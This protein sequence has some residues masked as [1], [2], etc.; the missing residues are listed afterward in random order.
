MGAASAAFGGSYQLFLELS[1]NHKLSRQVGSSEAGT[2]WLKTLGPDAV[3][4]GVMRMAF[5]VIGESRISGVRHFAAG[6]EQRCVERLL[7]QTAV[8]ALDE[9]VL[10]GLARLDDQELDAVRFGPSDQGVGGQP[11]AGVQVDGI[12]AAVDPT[13]FSSAPPVRATM[14]SMGRTQYTAL[15]DC[16][17]WSRSGR[18]TPAWSSA[19]RP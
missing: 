19:C 15:C 5:A 11:R 7:T 6:I 1:S 10:V 17:P 3:S 2:A 13:P 9:C 12:R 8:A 18:G 14:G 4:Q 16:P